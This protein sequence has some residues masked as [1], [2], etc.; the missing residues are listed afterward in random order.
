MATVTF[1]SLN[2]EKVVGTNG[3]TTGA[4]PVPELDKSVQSVVKAVTA[5][6]LEDS[7]SAP[8][9]SLDQSFLSDTS[10]DAELESFADTEIGELTA[11]LQDLLTYYCEA[12][13]FEIPQETVKQI[14]VSFLEHVEDLDDLKENFQKLLSAI[15][16]AEYEIT[17]DDRLQIKL[18]NAQYLTA[19][20]CALFMKRHF[21]AL[22]HALQRASELSLGTKTVAVLPITFEMELSFLGSYLDADV[23][24]SALGKGCFG[25]VN[26]IEFDGHQF[27][28]KTPLLDD[29]RTIKKFTQEII[30]NALLNGSNYITPTHLLDL[31]EELDPDGLDSCDS[32]ERS[33]FICMEYLP[34]DFSRLRS[35]PLTEDKLA[36][37]AAKILVA[38]LDLHENGI[39][40]KDLKPDNIRLDDEL[41]PYLTDF[42]LSAPTGS[43]A[44]SGTTKFMAKEILLK[45]KQDGRVDIW[46]LG[47]ILYKMATTRDL[48]KDA[49][50][51]YTQITPSTTTPHKEYSDLSKTEALLFIKTKL[52]QKTIDTVLAFVQQKNLFIGMKTPFL[53]ESFLRFLHGCLQIDPETRLSTK[54]ALLT[55]PISGALDSSYLESLVPDGEDSTTGASAGCAAQ[56]KEVAKEDNEDGES[57]KSSSSEADGTE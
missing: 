22:N 28:K 35:A 6:S 29:P 17:P 52:T 23:D 30:Y 14:E 7:A 49:Y 37:T 41:N 34:E 42:G 2:A 55:Y 24:T 46:S 26:L 39:I 51:I 33:P 40:H 31:G 53:S 13:P 45:Q 32:A 25:K 38:L 15:E 56:S 21:S 11:S 16:T 47:A 10:Y 3:A 48:L 54:E 5:L 4:S 9:P 18:F 57:K 27:A 19:R 12:A 50:K 1:K 44:L 36:E 20:K 43:T 8:T